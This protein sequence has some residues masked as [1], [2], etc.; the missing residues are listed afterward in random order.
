M[1]NFYDTLSEKDQRRYAA[2]EVR[3]LPHGGAKYVAEVLGCC[4]RRLHRGK[5]DLQRLPQ[6]PARGRIRKEGAGRPKKSN[7]ARKSG[8]P[9]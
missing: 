9:S 4:P 8:R 2:V 6:D 5:E 1:K 7:G 3:K